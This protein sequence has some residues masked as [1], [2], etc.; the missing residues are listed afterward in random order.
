MSQRHGSDSQKGPKDVGTCSVCWSTFKVQRATGHIHRHGHRNN[1]CPGSDQPPASVS[2]A[3]PSS[4]QSQQQ[5][6]TPGAATSNSTSATPT[7]SDTRAGERLSHPP[8]TTLVNRI[9]RAAR[10]ACRQ[11]LTQI[12]RKIVSTPNDK[13]AF[14]ELVHFGPVILAKPK[15]SGA[16]RNMSNIINKR[17]ATWD[18]NLTLVRPREDRRA[19][20]KTTE[21]SKLAAAVT[22]KLEAGNFKAAVRIICSSDTPAAANEETLKALRTKHP[23]PPADRRTACDPQGN[24]RF[25]PLQVSK[26]D[27][28]RALRSFPLGS[29]GGPDGLTPQHL[30]DLLA[31]STDDNLQQALVDFVNL[32]LAGAF[33]K[34]VNTI[35]FGGRLIALSK[36]DGG[37]RPISVGYTLRRLAAKCANS[38]VIAKRSQALQP[39]QL[40]V[41]VAGG[42]EAAIHATRRLVQNLPPG[43]VIVKLDLY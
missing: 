27:V 4:Y 1:P 39:Q 9:P 25:D 12:I 38:H 6:N 7:S 24:V 42:A 23:D 13:A 32:M 10:P 29:S 20:K 18:E 33:E 17:V 21:S 36:K 2:A 35:I 41:G 37:I 26:E 30:T 22:N 11:L 43:H 28:R 16:N 34:E 14:K 31:G 3:Q 40:G 15:R 8:W 19:S 5:A